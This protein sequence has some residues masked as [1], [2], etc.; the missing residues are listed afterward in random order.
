MDF[1]REYIKMRNS[2]KY[3]LNFF[4][5]YY[6]SKGGKVTDPGEFTEHF[7]YTHTIHP[8]PA[9]YPPIKIRNGEIDREEVLN[10]MDRVFELVI[11]KDKE[12]NFIKV[13]E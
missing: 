6:L 2:G 4:Y 10:H 1:K 13:V 3:E 12:N 9:N 7:V 8:T 11:L 5:N